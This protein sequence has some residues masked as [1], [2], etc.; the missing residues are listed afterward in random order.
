MQLE[1]IQPAES[2][3]ACS[4]RDRRITP[5]PR[6]SSDLAASP[7]PSV[8]AD[9]LNQ[10]GP[11]PAGQVTG[12]IYGYRVHGPYEPEA[13]HR[14]NPN[15]LLIDPYAKGL[16]GTIEWNPALFGYKMETGDDLTFDGRDSA[17]YTRRSRVIDPAFT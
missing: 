9:P 6:A 4:R 12:T 14:F 16:V 7:T 1:S 11:K 17:S 13:G 15:K 8:P 10:P 2:N 5:A 3:K